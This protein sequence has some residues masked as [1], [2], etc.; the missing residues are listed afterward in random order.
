MAL[1][2]VGQSLAA[3]NNGLTT[4]GQSLS[5]QGPEIWTVLTVETG[6]RGFLPDRRPQILYERHIFSRLT[7]G[8][9]DDGDISSSTPGG[10]GPGGANQYTR[11]ARAIALNRSAALQS[12][13]WGLGQIMGMNFQMAG[14]ADVETMVQTMCDSEDGHLA[15]FASFLQAKNL[16]A[17]LQAH[18]WAGVAKGYNG[19]NYAINQY[20]TKLAAAYQQLAAGGMPDFSVR[21]AQLYLTFCGYNTGGIDGIIGN[22]TRAAVSSFQTKQG[23]PATGV[24]DDS[25]L[26]S[27]AQ[28]ALAPSS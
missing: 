4:A 15:A 19:A 6:A 9:F 21:A 26:A 14:F 11:L 28:V 27:L 24:V 13:S 10:Y 16:A 23:L 5:V 8:Q 2:F 22:M 18:N 17:P 1:E 25:L 20:D 3:T 12:A 7:N